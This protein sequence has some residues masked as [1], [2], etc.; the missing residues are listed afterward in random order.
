MDAKATGAHMPAADH[1]PGYAA[2][3]LPKDSQVRCDV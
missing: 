3:H 2:V 1:L